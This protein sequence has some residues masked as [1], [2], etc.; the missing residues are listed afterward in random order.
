MESSL[1]GSQWAITIS[2]ASSHSGVFS[3]EIH[4]LLAIS[5][6]ISR[7]YSC[8]ALN[9]LL[10]FAAF[11]TSSL[12]RATFSAVSWQ[13]SLIYRRTTVC[14]PA[15]YRPLL[16]AAERSRSIWVI[17]KS[18]LEFDFLCKL[19][20]DFR[21][22]SMRTPHWGVFNEDSRSDRLPNGLEKDSSIVLPNRWVHPAADQWLHYAVP[23][24]WIR[25]SS[26]KR[27]RVWDR[28]L[29]DH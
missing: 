11:W 10:C 1:F 24:V 14:W 21:C 27:T 13:C 22:S 19:F 25:W 15:A 9:W 23:S 2:L 3:S 28:Y 26:P 7:I 17:K 5:S 4:L 12:L 6:W 20:F 16:R 18:N 29:P 8:A